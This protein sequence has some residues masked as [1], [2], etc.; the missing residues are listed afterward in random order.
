MRVEKET[1]ESLM[2]KLEGKIF[3]ANIVVASATV[4][5]L[6]DTGSY[7]KDLQRA[8]LRLCKDLDIEIPMWMKKN[9]NEFARFR[10]TVFYEEQFMRKYSF[11]RF[12]I[13]ELKE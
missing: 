2:I 3:K 13:K 7:V 8:F 4:V 1:E 5:E 10:Q 6:D 11:D 9:T 12:Q